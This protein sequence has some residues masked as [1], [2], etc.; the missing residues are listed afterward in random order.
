MTCTEVLPNSRISVTPRARKSSQRRIGTTTPCFAA[1]ACQERAAVRLAGVAVHLEERVAGFDELADGVPHHH[2]A[3][4]PACPTCDSAEVDGLDGPRASG[5]NRERRRLGHALE[6]S[7]EDVAEIPH[8]R[9]VVV[10][11]L[12]YRLR[13]ERG[14]GRRPEQVHEPVEKQSEDD[15]P[16]DEQHPR[17]GDPEVRNEVNLD[18]TQQRE[19]VRERADQQREHA[20]QHGVAVPEPHGP[21]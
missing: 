19:R 11:A 8:V 9:Q 16:D 4:T 2:E 5:P 3:L 1:P 14:D 20:L 12:A 15:Q 21:R 6:R 10:E 7:H 13:D 18:T 17:K